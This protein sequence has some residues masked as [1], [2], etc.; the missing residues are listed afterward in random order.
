[1]ISER[2]LRV[3]TSVEQIQFTTKS[4]LERKLSAFALFVREYSFQ[5]YCLGNLFMQNFATLQFPNQARW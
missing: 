4:P 5:I 3:I 1:M 2:S